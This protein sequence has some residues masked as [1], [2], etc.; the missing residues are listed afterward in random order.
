M[1]P[2]PLLEIETRFAT[3]QQEGASSSTVQTEL[4]GKKGLLPLFLRSLGQFSPEERKQYG[5]AALALRETIEHYIEA[6]NQVTP[7]QALDLGDLTLPALPQPNGSYHPVKAMMRE[8]A[9]IFADLSFEVVEGP[10]LV[11]DIDNFENLN[12]TKDHPARDGHKSFIIANNLFLRTQTTAVQVVEMQRR[13][14]TKD[15]PI[16]VVVPGRTYRR[17]SDQ[18]HSPMFHQIDAVVVDTQTTFA[19]LKGSL[20]YFAKRLFGDTVETRFRPHYFPF[21]EPS[22][23]M[24]IK[25]KNATGS[26]K[27]TEWL[28]F[29]GCG[30]IHP[31]VLKRAGINPRIYR[32]WAFGMS[33]ERPVMLR[34][35][36]PDLRLLFQN[37]P[38]F[39]NQFKGLTC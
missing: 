33:I 1:K 21:T 38:D 32:G 2:N 10:E 36:I 14:K 35:Q 18:T 19:D 20:E 9:R 4:L 17:E 22:A 26:G 29:G 27:H 3:L 39:L 23:E 8:M 5:Q 15:M 12:I 7:Q 34:Y 31:A 16:R 6:H 11:S 28:E 24:D 13:F 25:L 30:M 37:E